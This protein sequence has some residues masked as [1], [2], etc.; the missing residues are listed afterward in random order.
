MYLLHNSV[1]FACI[2]QLVLTFISI[3]AQARFI[4]HARS[5]QLWWIGDSGG[6]RIANK[7]VKTV[8]V[9]SLCIFFSFLSFVRKKY[10]NFGVDKWASCIRTFSFNASMPRSTPSLFAGYHICM[11]KEKGWVEA[12]HNKG[13]YLTLYSWRSETSQLSYTVTNIAAV[14]VHGMCIATSLLSECMN[15]KPYLLRLCWILLSEK[16][17]V[18]IILAWTSMLLIQQC[19]AM[20]RP[21]NVEWVTRRFHAFIF[22]FV[23]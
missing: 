1:C 10:S 16:G 19:R 13:V 6:F 4:C 3:D 11:T 21:Q 2:H 23:I 14:D 8:F 7:L 17:C 20:R 22:P 12:R 5:F 15:S 18:Y 9:F